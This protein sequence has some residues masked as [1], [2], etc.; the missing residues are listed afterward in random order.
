M[1]DPLNVLVIDGHPDQG[2][3]IGA[4][5]DSWVRALPAGSEVA[6]IAVRELTFGLVLCRGYGPE[7]AWEAGLARVGAVADRPS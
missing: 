6:R 3:I 7:Q 2:R 5:L 4:P 1:A